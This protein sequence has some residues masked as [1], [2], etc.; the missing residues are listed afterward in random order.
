LIILILL[1]LH[2][3]IILSCH[4]RIYL[5]TLIS[6]FNFVEFTSFKLHLAMTSSTSTQPM[7]HQAQLTSSVSV[8]NAYLLKFSHRNSTLSPTLFSMAPSSKASS[9][10]TVMAKHPGTPTPPYYLSLCRVF[11]HG[12]EIDGNP[13]SSPISPVS[14]SAQE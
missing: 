2:H 3:P 12:R 1:I 7:T 13:S 14:K 6:S 9:S 4:H 5:D 10:M 11:H 8:P